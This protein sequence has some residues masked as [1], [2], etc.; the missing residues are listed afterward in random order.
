MR[1]SIACDYSFIFQEIK[2]A[3]FPTLPSLKVKVARERLM[4]FTQTPKLLP[5]EHILAR[6]TLS[7][8]HRS[9]V[10]FMVSRYMSL[11]ISCPVITSPFSGQQFSRLCGSS[12]SRANMRLLLARLCPS[13][14]FSLI[15]IE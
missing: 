14:A 12:S 5:A 8:I 7:C 15:H 10:D 3:L 4:S 13:L 9:R 2:V 1:D 11:F 6:H